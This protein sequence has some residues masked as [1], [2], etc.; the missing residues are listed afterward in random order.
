MFTRVLIANRGEIALR[1]ARACRE[2][3][4]G[5]VA[6]Y[7]TADRE[8]AW[9]GMA[10]EA[11][12]I[13]PAAAR[14]SYL[15]I[16][17]LIEAAHR[18]GADAIHPGYGFLSE[19]QDFAE[20]CAAE[21][22]TFIGPSPEVMHRVCD[23][24]R[25]R[26]LMA[27][28]GLPLL[29][30]S[31]EPVRSVA[32]GARMA[33]DIGFPVI[34]K[35]VA[36]G[37]GRGMSVVR[38][39]DDFAAAFTR[40]QSD[41][42]ALFGCPDVYLERYLAAA[43]HVEVQVLA[44]GDGRGIHLG[45][46]ECSIQRRQQK[47]LAESPCPELD[48]QQRTQLGE[49]A[50]AGA[51]SV[52]LTGAGTME[53]LLDESGGLYFM[54]LNAR[55]QVEHPV[56][57]MITGIDIVREQILI[58]AGAALQYTQSDI[59]LMG[60]AMECRVNAEDPARGFAPAPGTLT[61]FIPPA[62]PWT[63]VETGY[64]QGDRVNAHYDSLMAKV[65]V[66][67]PDRSQAIRRMDRALGEFEVSGPGVATTLTLHRNLLRSGVFRRGLC[68]TSYLERHLP[69][70][71]EPAPI[72]M[73]D[74]DRPLRH[75][76]S[77]AQIRAVAHPPQSKGVRP[78]ATTHFAVSD[79]MELLTEKAGLPRHK[80]TADP[81]ATLDDVGLDSLAF[82]AIQCGLEQ[83]Y[84]FSLPNEGPTYCST[85]GDIAGEVDARLQRAEAPTS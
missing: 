33:A 54:E 84:G 21:G 83:R 14:R 13:G 68:T 15:N 17:A 74:R 59:R 9:V 4:I 63:R 66:W 77:I 25:V 16:P 34:I 45:E 40:T 1:V 85:V 78:M 19:D 81:D 23:K 79:L 52:G 76:S 43:R 3:D 6:A 36:G 69:E 67:A 41:A 72:G 20:I 82:L 10:D 75:R 11:V 7:S 22:V 65:V 42:R 80:H 55:I 58:S 47:L 48:D 12:H 26:T 8:S 61:R 51:L 29:P 73:P 39:A 56:T 5:V 62:G 50:V 35:A 32:A 70:L 60:A 30:G 71:I 2:L 31:V 49:M 53:F 46:R 18:S 44:D 37:G 57:E 24:S 38:A 27:D 28:A 64:R